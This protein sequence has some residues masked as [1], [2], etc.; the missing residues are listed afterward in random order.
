MPL[1][2][3]RAGRRNRLQD[4]WEQCVGA[5]AFGKHRKPIAPDPRTIAAREADDYERV[6]AEA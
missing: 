6:V 1:A 3:A 2:C 5:E 4:V